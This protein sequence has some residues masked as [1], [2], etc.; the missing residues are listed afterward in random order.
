MKKKK[1]S[2]LMLAGIFMLACTGCSS[3]NA[4]PSAAASETEAASEAEIEDLEEEIDR[5]IDV[6]LNAYDEKGGMISI[7]ETGFDG[8]SETFEMG[9]LGILAAEGE[10]IGHAM[11]YFGY[12][13][14]TPVPGDYTFEGWLEYVEVES[15][16][17]DGFESMHYELLTD[18]LYTTEQLF[19]LTVP[20]HAVNYIAKWA[21]IPAEK[22]FHSEVW[23]NAESSGAFAFSSNGGEM[24]FFAYDEEFTSNTYTYWMDGGQAL[25]DIMGTEYGA[26]LIGIEKDGAEFTGWTLYE[27]DSAFWNDEPTEEDGITSFLFDPEDEDVQYLLLR[28]AEVIRE[29][30]STEELCGISIEDGKCYFAEANWE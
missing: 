2:A 15:V 1:L 10:T 11:D 17:E 7:T 20:D 29:L 25:N 16:D 13:D 23:E 22:Y 27:G 9:L 21:E 8:S 5:E 12:S 4:E 28:N 18:K 19:E 6:C 30:S 3:Q 14:I 26:A 24:T